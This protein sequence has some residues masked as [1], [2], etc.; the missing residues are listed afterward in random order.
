MEN[1]SRWLETN[2]WK[3][4]CLKFHHRFQVILD[5]I[6]QVDFKA[7]I[8]IY[9]IVPRILH[10]YILVI[11]SIFLTVIIKLDVSKPKVWALI[12]FL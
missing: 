2:K 1:T 3:L 7:Y 9:K 4:V 6:S 10:K 12:M 8:Y 5:F 11:Y